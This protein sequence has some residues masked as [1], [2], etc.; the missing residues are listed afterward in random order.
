[1]HPK[2]IEYYSYT[3]AQAIARIF[4]ELSEDSTSTDEETA[5]DHARRILKSIYEDSDAGTISAAEAETVYTETAD[6]YL[7][8][9]SNFH[10]TDELKNAIRSEYQRRGSRANLDIFHRIREELQR[11]NINII[12]YMM[13]MQYNEL[14]DTKQS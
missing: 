9:I 4:A 6:K 10:R 14:E 5:R 7:Y 2:A 13:L 12:E 11:E 1:M 8:L 3:K